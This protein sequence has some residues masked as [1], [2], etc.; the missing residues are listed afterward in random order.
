M[1][2]SHTIF[3]TALTVAGLE[4][5]ADILPEAMLTLKDVPITAYATPSSHEDAEVIR[6]WIGDHDAILLRQH[7]SLTVGKN[8]G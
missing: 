8:L 3:A 5:P 2:H 4:F 7:G 1:I 6:P